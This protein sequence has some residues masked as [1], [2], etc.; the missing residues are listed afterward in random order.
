MTSIL[1][2]GTPQFSVPTLEKLCTTSGLRVA[3]VVTQPDRPAGRGATITASPVKLCAT[4]HGVPVVQP[5]SIKRELAS[6]RA[7]VAAFG[8]FDVGVVI[9]FGQILPIEVLELP[10]MGCVNIHASILPRWRGAAP[11]QRAIEAGDA[12]TGVCLMQMEAGLDTGAVYSHARTP[13][14]ASET[15]ETLHDRLSLMGADLLVR[16][17]NSIINGSLHATPQ[18]PEGISY[19]HKI[20]ANE[21]RI[22]WSQSAAQISRKIRSLYPHP[23]CHTFL[24]GKRVKIIRAHPVII[25]VDSVATPGTVLQALPDTVTV[26]CGDGALRLE[27]LQG[28]GKRRMPV[29]EFMRGAA[30]R[31]GVVCG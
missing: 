3:A 4:R 9:A 19:A 12:E 16:D 6:F 28:E 14:H 10:R 31:A 17:L 15:Y 27:E 23:G 11:I 8:P 30:V 21:T 25:P 29:A 5:H 26:Q 18:S 24:D 13:I 22:D 1:F 2:F 7:A 20:S